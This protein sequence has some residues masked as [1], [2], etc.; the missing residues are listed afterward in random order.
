M[1]PAVELLAQQEGL[2]SE[3]RYLLRTAAW[4]HD[5]GFVEKP[6]FHE[7]LSARIALEVLPTFGYS[8]RQIDVVRWAIFATIIPQDPHTHLEQ[9]LTDAD[10]SV[11]GRPDFL[12]YNNY[13][14]QELA[15]FDKV[16]SEVE[17][18]KNQ[19]RFYQTHT[20]FTQ[21]ARRLFDAQKSSNINTIKQLLA[22]AEASRAK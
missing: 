19:L 6:A 15:F 5:I 14:R 10:L 3:Q 4:F 22:Q 7:L 21:S 1:V 11:L 9:V 20:F 16:Y 12:T 13:L 8:L 2:R 18:L 17:W